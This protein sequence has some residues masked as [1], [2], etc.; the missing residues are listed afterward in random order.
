[1][2]RVCWMRPVRQYRLYD[3]FSHIRL[4]STSGTRAGTGGCG[5]SRGRRAWTVWH[6]GSVTDASPIPDPLDLDGLVGDWLTL[7]DLAERWGMPVT[8]VRAL[9]GDRELVAVRRGQ[10][11][12]LHVPARFAA[13]SGPR[14]D[15][16]GTITVLADAGM[17][18]DEVVAWLFSPDAGLPDDMT[19]MT[20]LEAGYRALVRRQAQLT[21]W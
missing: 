10:N 19:P 17:S 14:A 15:L 2:W 1:M 5:E 7:P 6:P 12:A 8:K 20:A 16:K 11:R 4:S 21:A 9:I 13:A 18:D 3:G